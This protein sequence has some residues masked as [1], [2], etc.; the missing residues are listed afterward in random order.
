MRTVFIVIL[1]KAFVLSSFYFY[2]MKI[3]KCV[4]TLASQKMPKISHVTTS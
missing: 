2:L 1:W 3:S 4:V